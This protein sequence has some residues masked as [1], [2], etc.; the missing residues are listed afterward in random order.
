MR[1]AK[2]L[3]SLN[4][5]G[6]VCYSVFGSV[7]A[8]DND[9]TNFERAYKWRSLSEGFR[10]AKTSRKPIFLLV[11][12]PGCPTCENLQAKIVKSIRILDLSQRF[13]MVRVKKGELSTQDEARFQPDGTYVPRILFFTPDGEFIKDIYNRHPKADDKYKYFY[14]STSQI[15]DSMLLALEHCSK[16]LLNGAIDIK[17]KK[18]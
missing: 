6:L 11:H 16:D 13:V 5:A 17:M 1:Y 14:S 9:T 12:K 3:G 10:E 8:A 2:C 18:K 15:I 4:I 7:I